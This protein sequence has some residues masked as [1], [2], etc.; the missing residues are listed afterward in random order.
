[1][2]CENYPLTQSHSPA[3]R[4]ISTISFAVFSFEF[5]PLAHQIL[6]YLPHAQ[7]VKYLCPDEVT[8]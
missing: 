5:L 6:D 8:M 3:D 2:R 1:M 4:N 7:C